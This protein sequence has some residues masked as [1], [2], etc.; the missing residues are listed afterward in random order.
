M[1][2]SL[3]PLTEDNAAKP[4]CVDLPSSQT[5]FPISLRSTGGWWTGG[6]CATACSGRF[7]FPAAG[8]DGHGHS[9]PWPTCFSLR[10]LL[11]LSLTCLLVGHPERVSLE[12]DAPAAPLGRGGVHAQEQRRVRREAARQQAAGAAGRDV[13]EQ[14]VLGVREHLREERTDGE[15]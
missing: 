13:D 1:E 14:L 4:N 12:G 15:T 9:L 8:N 11:S 5:D 2:S 6:G 10:S 7:E 3:V